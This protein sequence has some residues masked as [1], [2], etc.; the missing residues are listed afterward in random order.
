MKL[1]GFHISDHDANV[2]YFDGSKVRYHK[3]E[4]SLQIK[5]YG[6]T[7]GLEFLSVLNK[8]NVDVGTVDDVAVVIDNEYTDAF[9]QTL[10]R[11]FD[12]VEHHYAHSLSVWPVTNKDI[13]VGFVF[14]GDGDDDKSFSIYE[15]SKLVHS[16]TNEQC[17]SFGTLL[18]LAAVSCGIT[19]HE[20]DLAGKAMGLKSYGNIDTELLKINQQLTLEQ[21]DQIAEQFQGLPLDLLATLH[22]FAETKFP[23]YFIEKSAPWSTISFTGGVSQNS[24]ING[25]LAKAHKDIIIPPHGGDEGLSL[26]CL[27]FLRI[28]HNLDPFDTT[29]FPFWQDDQAPTTEV[30]LQTLDKVASLL[31]QGK[32]V[33][34]YQGH[35]EV[36]PRALGNRSILMDP[37]IANGKDLLNQ[38]VKHR[39]NFRPFGCSVLEEYATEYF[40]IKEPSPYMLHVVDTKTKDFPAIT[41]IDSTTRIQ[42]VS[43]TAT[44]YR[45]LME[46]FYQLTDC[47]I[48]LN[49]SLNVNGRPIA[50]YIND[51]MDLFNN[52]KIDAV[53]IGG[54]LIV[55]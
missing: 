30:N 3:L 1:L 20:L 37:R 4:R 44:L 26:G 40:D 31:A 45:A 10:D 14:D 34:W 43:E 49:T 16:M 55:K 6:T 23:E 5:H 46:S 2:S 52:S 25:H 21:I 47:P 7:T 8:W 36:G 24:V 48:L 12:R 11:R 27:E 35:G 28:K 32:I 50:G 15:E 17:S 22:K 29:G 38:Q 39:E 9:E 42:T 41:H 13:D 54:D 33:A 19:G 18:E 53:C 51:A